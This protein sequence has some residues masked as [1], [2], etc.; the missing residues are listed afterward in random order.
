MTEEL[1]YEQQHEENRPT[2]IIGEASIKIQHA[3]TSN[4]TIKKYKQPLKQ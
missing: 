1:N 4:S 3:K 2:E